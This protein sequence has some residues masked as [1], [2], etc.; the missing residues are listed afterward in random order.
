MNDNL[1]QFQSYDPINVLFDHSVQHFS[2][3]HK[4]IKLFQMPLTDQEWSSQ[5]PDKM[6]KML[7]LTKYTHEMPSLIQEMKKVIPSFCCLSSSNN[8]IQ[9]QIIF[10]QI[11]QYLST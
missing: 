11:T 7:N 2:N 5:L 9:S 8:D 4:K 10:K 3:E 6:E 1:L